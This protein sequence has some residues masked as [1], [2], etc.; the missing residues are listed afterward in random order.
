MD[1]RS[2]RYRIGLERKPP[3]ERGMKTGKT[4]EILKDKVF[5][6]IFMPATIGAIL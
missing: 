6:I 3:G 5:L 1:L 4:K 2:R